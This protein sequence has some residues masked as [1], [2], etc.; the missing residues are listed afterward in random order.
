MN[1]K[2]LAIAVAAGLAVP[3]AAMADVTIY[4]KFNMGIGYADNDGGSSNLDGS[5]NDDQ[6]KGMQVMSNSSRIGFKGSEDLGG[7]L[8]VIWQTETLVDPNGDGNGNFSTRNT[9]LGLS[10][11]FGKVFVGR[12]DTPSKTNARKVDFFGDQFGDSRT[13]IRGD[14]WNVSGASVDLDQRATN[15][16]NYQSPKFAG[17]LGVNLQ[18][19]PDENTESDLNAPRLDDQGD[20]QQFSGA[21]F[22]DQGGLYVGGDY[23]YK[24]DG[25][26]GFGGI[27]GVVDN[28]DEAAYALAAGYKFAFGLR[29]AGFYRGA[30]SMNNVD[31]AD[32]AMFGAGA[33][34]T[35]GKNVIKAQ[36]YASKED[37]DNNAGLA[38]CGDNGSGGYQDCDSVVYAIG[39]DHNFSKQTT[40]QV[41]FAAADNDDG[42]AATPWAGGGSDQVN[43]IG[44]AGALGNKPYGFAVGLV[45]KF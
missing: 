13:I 44:Q 16:I 42:V 14:A 28:D 19:V 8:S 30:E 31:G 32:M 10:T 43:D 26:Y 5:S 21:V 41:N 23:Q 37:F 6:D 22:W 33:S 25:T 1:K 4:G 20:S 38:Y 12:Y 36:A 27:P 2:L 29:I 18:Y 7:G 24:E 11:G 17:G 35:F 39:W 45:H 40:L 34:Y 15:T 3:A 9:F